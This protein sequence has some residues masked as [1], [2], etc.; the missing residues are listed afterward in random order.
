MKV[1]LELNVHKV[2]TYSFRRFAINRMIDAHNGDF[3]KVVADSGHLRGG[4]VKAFYAR[5]KKR[6]QELGAEAVD[7]QE[8]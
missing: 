2:T 5:W 1:T 8:V 7:D 6:A 4:T 3:D